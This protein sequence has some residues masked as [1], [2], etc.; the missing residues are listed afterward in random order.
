M[1]GTGNLRLS[2][3]MAGPSSL[4]NHSALPEPGLGLTLLRELGSAQ[5][6]LRDLP[7]WKGSQDCE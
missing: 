6:V 3:K 7:C 4:R 1:G 5:L 2:R